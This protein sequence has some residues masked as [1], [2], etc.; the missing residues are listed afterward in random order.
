[1]AD[2]G[3]T[4]SRPASWGDKLTPGWWVKASDAL[5]RRL[6]GYGAGEG[7]PQD[8]TERLSKGLQIIFRAA[9]S[10]DLGEREVRRFLGADQESSA[11]LYI[12]LCDDLVERCGPLIARQIAETEDSETDRPPSPSAAVES[13]S[14]QDTGSPFSPQGI[15]VRRPSPGGGPPHWWQTWIG[16][17]D[18]EFETESR[19]RE[20]VYGTFV[21]ALGRKG[22]SFSA[23]PAVQPNPE[24]WKSMF[25]S[26][27]AI[28]QLAIGIPG[29]ESDDAY[30]FARHL[31]VPVGLRSHWLLGELVHA[32]WQFEYMDAELYSDILAEFLFSKGAPKGR[33]GRVR[34]PLRDYRTIR[35]SVEEPDQFGAAQWAFGNWRPDIIDFARSM[36]FEIKPLRTAHHGVLQ[37]WRYAH[38]FNCAYYFDWL[39]K[40]GAQGKA[41]RM[42]LVPGTTNG[43]YFREVDPSSFLEE[44]FRAR[45]AAS[46]DPAAV[47]QPKTKIPKVRQRARRSEIEGVLRAGGRMKI[48]PFT[49]HAIPGLVLY[50]VESERT[51]EDGESPRIPTVAKVALV[52]VGVL[53]VGAVIV[54]VLSAAGTATAG[55]AVATAGG[56]SATGALAEGSAALATVAPA[57]LG[58]APVSASVPVASGGAGTAAAELTVSIFNVT[59]DAKQLPAATQ[60][61]SSSM[62]QMYAG[63]IL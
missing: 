28:A 48:L 60:A 7:P 36:I 17:Q 14:G 54:A 41:M 13:A 31:D 46:D 26:A 39:E 43:S 20:E 18:A 9:I 6:I 2:A 25:D 33:S 3:T 1:M 63:N 15:D 10:D 29:D 16:K 57:A 32:Q 56:A 11:T 49:A 23:I 38:N 55:V 42:P 44:Y 4:T 47:S 61:I 12:R 53:V 52:V 19:R 30:H 22:K 51:K 35:R 59:L 21:T 40:P 5:L 34:G 62:S 8:E 37:L 24:Y 45:A 27:R 50:R 58:T